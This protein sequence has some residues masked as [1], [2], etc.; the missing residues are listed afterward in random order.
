MPT[1]D[2]AGR[3]LSR[4]VAV[5]AEDAFF[6]LAAGGPEPRE[7]LDG[8][9]RRRMDAYQKIM[10]DE[11]VPRLGDDAGHWIADLTRAMAAVA[12]PVWLPMHEVLAE[13]VTLEV[14]ARGLRSL[15][16]SKPS[17]KDVQRVKRLGTLA[18]RALRAVLAAR[19]PLDAD[20]L[21]T[22][23]AFVAAL[24]L[25]EQDANALLGE[26]PRPIEQLDVYGDIEPNV[27]RA[28]MRGAWLAA[29]LGAIDPRQEVVL[30]TL[31]QKLGIAPEAAEAAR[32]EAVTRVEDR[33]QAGMA[34]VDVVR[35]VLSDRVPGLGVQLAAQAG[36]LMLPR[37]YRDEAL[38]QVGHGAPVTLARRH[39]KLSAD[40]RVTAL[41]M[42]WAAA[43]AEDPTVSRRTVLRWRYDL[44]AADLGDDGVRARSMIDG[45]VM[46]TLAEVARALK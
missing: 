42:G 28:V 15:F 29:A 4:L 18:A 11:P 38:A 8:L 10:A 6:A 45:F 27:A 25:P 19:G 7:A 12:P 24:G 35:F 36:T 2:E 16:S 22:M 21:Q 9:A 43:L 3:A 41:G 30:G 39:E 26:E 34:A 17:D 44:M 32:A 33:R 37:R 1:V 31:A 40:M 23:L 13:K 46:E 20:D 14:G 5:L